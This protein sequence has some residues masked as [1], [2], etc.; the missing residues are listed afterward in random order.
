MLFETGRIPGGFRHE[1]RQIDELTMVRR[2][3]D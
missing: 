2:I 3:G 1:G